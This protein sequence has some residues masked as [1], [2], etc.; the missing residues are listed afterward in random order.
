MPSSRPVRRTGYDA[1]L[2]LVLVQVQ[3][4]QV[5]LLDVPSF[6]CSVRSRHTFSRL[7][8]FPDHEFELRS[9]NAS[10]DR[11]E[12]SADSFDSHRNPW[13]QPK[14]C[15]LANQLGLLRKRCGREH[16]LKEHIH[17]DT[18]KQLAPGN[19]PGASDHYNINLRE[20]QSCTV[21]RNQV[22]AGPNL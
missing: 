3:V 15:L 13:R 14:T 17:K 1:Q 18:I 2:F 10:T 4:V 7:P 19:L 8:L 21:I 11:W 9:R 16:T 12:A 20:A 6:C 5:E 22:S